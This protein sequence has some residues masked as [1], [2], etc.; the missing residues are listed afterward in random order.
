MYKLSFDVKHK[1]HYKLDLRDKKIL[2]FLA[3]NARMNFTE[4]ARH[5]NLSK[6]S[7]QYRFHKLLEKKIILQTYALLDYEKLGF[8]KYHLLLLLDN[9]KKDRI[10]EF[11]TVLQADEAVMRI[12]RF[13]DNWDLEIVVL[14]R[15]LREFDSVV[16]RLLDPFEDIVLQ[17][18]TEAVIDVVENNAFPEVREL[19]LNLE[20]QPTVIKKEATI[21]LDN[22]IDL[23]ILS[24]LTHNA[25]ISTYEIAKQVPL[26]ADA[27]G[28]RIKRL[29]KAGVI[30]DFTCVLNFS[31]L[32]YQGYVFCFSAGS[33]SKRQEQRFL[34]YVSR[35]RYVISVKKMVGTWDIKNYVVVKDPLELHR[36]IDELKIN[37]SSILKKY[38]TWVIYKE[39]FF[40]PFPKVLLK[41]IKS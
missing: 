18:D 12:I 35:N 9:S 15:H 3:K 26:S 33:M 30:L 7:V 8:Q 24:S 14:A 1:K 10:Q 4:I 19:S 31:D 40:N 39:Y 22:I 20:Q 11:Q 5:V 28:L 38:E 23:Q 36:L 32:D 29:V 17:K 16:Q 41:D 37:F 6:E 27:I 25:R 13:S 2:F 34:E 21:A